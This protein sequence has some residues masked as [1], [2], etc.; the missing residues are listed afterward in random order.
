[1]KTQIYAHKNVEEAVASAQVGVNFIGVT[2]GQNGRLPWELDFAL[3]KAIFAA[4]RAVSEA[5]VVALTI[6]WTE[7]E[8]VETVF[9]TQP[10]IIHLSGDYDRYSPDMVRSLRSHVTPTKVMMAVPVGNFDSVEKAKRFASAADF[11]I[12]D[13]D[14]SQ[15][16][17]VGAT[18]EVH[19][20][21]VSAEIVRQ[22]NIPVIL[23]GGLSPLNVQQAI[24]SV[25]PWAVD[26]YSHTN[27]DDSRYKDIDKVRA[28]VQAAQN[29][30]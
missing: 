3:C 22:V 9:Q 5:C 15:V 1:M 23:A 27:A 18:G 30:D 10:D 2:A 6:A 19:D 7:E 28:F 14:R 16:P 4:V 24:R 20:W 8:I 13:T 26:S 25:R 12:L 21:E 11:L 29:A 17:G